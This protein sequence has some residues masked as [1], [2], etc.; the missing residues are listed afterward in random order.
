MI[1]LDN[2]QRQAVIT[3]SD[4]TLVLAGAGSGK[5]RVLTERIAHLIENKQV[6]PY[7]IMA[8]T[9]T[10]KS[11]GEIKKRLADRIGG[12]AYNVTMGTMHGVALNMIQKFAELIGFRHNQI[13]VYSQWEE[14]FLLKEIAIDLGYHTGKSWKKIKK[15]DVTELFDGFY[16]RGIY[17][18]PD[19]KAYDLFKCFLAAVRSN[20]SLTYGTILTEFKRLIPM[21]MY[22]LNIRYVLVDEVQDIDPL[23]WSII[24]ILT[25]KTSLF[26]VGDLDQ[27]IY[28]FRGAD[29]GYLLRNAKDFDIFKI[30]TNYRSG[31]AI[32]AGANR[33]I[34]HNKDRFDKT[35]EAGSDIYGII[36]V[37]V[38]MDSESICEFIQAESPIDVNMAVLARNHVF[39]EK[40][41]SILSEKEINHTYIGKKTSFVNSESFRRFH[42]VLKLIVNPYDN[43][44]FLMIRDIIGLSRDDYNMVR[45]TASVRGCSHFQA[46]DEAKTIGVPPHSFIDIFDEITSRFNIIGENLYEIEAFMFDWYL[47]SASSDTE[48]DIKNYLKFIATYNINEEAASENPEGVQLMTIHAS[49]GLEFPTVIIAGCNEGILPSKRAESDTDELESERRLAYVG[50][51]RA[52][53]LLVLAVRPE[54]KEAASGMM[55]S[56]PVSRFIAESY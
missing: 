54:Q 37:T 24:N 11:A 10:R 17:P 9:F 12:M 1:N 33:L 26:A 38:D 56:N 2:Q 15:S 5:T 34:S 49:K 23:Q 32:V 42:A 55:M 14:D 53:E 16:N 35:M 20:N 18:Q 3:D 46:W 27:S 22:M 41:S 25:E 7:E 47:S 44:S 40:I 51:T 48:S 52:K 45:H 29:P 13:T 36:H 30:E 19:A 6:S 31:A 50:W 39:L 43:F 4:R 8:F 21:I 28:S